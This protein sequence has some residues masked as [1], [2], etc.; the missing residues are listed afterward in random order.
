LSINK[1]EEKKKRGGKKGEKA[2]KDLR[3]EGED[4]G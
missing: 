4:S 2:G 1:V 3:A